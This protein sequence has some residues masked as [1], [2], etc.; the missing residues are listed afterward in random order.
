MDLAAMRKELE[1][2]EDRVPWAYP[3]SLGYWTIGVGHLID[4][5]KGGKLPESIIDALLDFDIAEKVGQLH[6]QFPW[7]EDLDEVRQRVLVNMCFNLGIGGLS[8]FKNML[9]AVEG[10]NYE[11]AAEQMASSRWATQVGDRAT[12]LIAMMRTGSV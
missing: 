5:R 7:F 8:E 1:R 4:H 3:D 2:D 12:R 11:E 9:A 6:G 10:G